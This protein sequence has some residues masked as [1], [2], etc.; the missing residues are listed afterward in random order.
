[1][2]HVT[3]A[4][5]TLP[6]AMLRRRG[7]PFLIS[8]VVRTFGIGAEPRPGTVATDQ[9]SSSAALATTSAPEAKDGA[10]GDSE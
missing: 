4:D 3:S 8:A 1:M 2:S 9:R 5:D 6:S 10:L 7:S